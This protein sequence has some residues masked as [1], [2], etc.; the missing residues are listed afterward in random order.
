MGYTFCPRMIFIPDAPLGNVSRERMMA[1][2]S[3]VIPGIPCNLEF[4]KI[5]T[6]SDYSN[7]IIVIVLSGI[8]TSK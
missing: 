4:S 8:S 6:T 7:D 1:G 5:E 2:Q 3:I